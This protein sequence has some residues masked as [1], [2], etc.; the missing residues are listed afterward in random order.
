MEV[1]LFQVM[2]FGIIFFSSFLGRKAL[3]QISL[4]ICVFTFLAIFK[5][6]L[7]VLQFLTIFISY[8][9]AV[10][11]IKNSENSIQNTQT[12]STKSYS[13]ENQNSKGYASFIT[14][15]IIVISIYCAF[16]VWSK[17]NLNKDIPKTESVIQTENNNSTSGHL[18]FD[19]N[20]YSVNND[21]NNDNN[22]VDTVS[23]VE[24]EKE[25]NESEWGDSGDDV[26]FGKV[27]YG[28]F[29][30]KKNNNCA[31]SE[32]QLQIE[33]ID[34]FKIKILLQVSNYNFSGEIS[35]IAYL[36]ND[37]SRAT[38]KSEDCESII[39]DF[40][41]N[42]EIQVTELNCRNYHGHGI[43]FDSKFE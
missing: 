16:N 34:N 5:S 41:Y 8:S 11:R 21:T 25:E 43:C 38:F 42:G 18:I 23:A 30:F 39:L 2:L 13:S 32:G 1:F 12:T 26:Y 3:N 4:L 22:T 28:I 10:E 33:K 6:W 17:K 19:P 9:I 20:S 31:I 15:F 37:L 27:K 14:I 29:E 36:S 35:G 24:N 7:M 40:L